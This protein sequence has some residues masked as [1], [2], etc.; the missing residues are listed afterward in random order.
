VD[1]AGR[2]R[3]ALGILASIVPSAEHDGLLV[4]E[5]KRTTLATIQNG[6]GLRPGGLSAPVI[7]ALGATLLLGG[8]TVASSPLQSKPISSEHASSQSTIVADFP[9]PPP[10]Q[11]PRWS[12]LTPGSPFTTLFGGPGAPGITATVPYGD[13]FVAVGLDSRLDGP[14]NGAIWSSPDG[15]TWTRVGVA[16]ADLANVKLDMVATDGRRLIALGR[17]SASD[18]AHEGLDLI[19]WLSD[20]GTD[21]RR[22]ADPQ[23]PF[24]SAAIRGIVGGPSGFVA[25][26][27]DGG[28]AALFHSA[29][30][31]SWERL[32][33]GTLFHGAGIGSVKPYRGGFVAVGGR[34]APGTDPNV[35]TI[36]GP[37]LST[38][39][40][41]WSPDGRTWYAAETETG[42]GLGSV[43]VGADGLLS[44]GSSGH[45]GI[46]RGSFGTLAMDARGSKSG[47][48][49][50]GIPPT[51]PTVPGS[52]ASTGRGRVTFQRPPMA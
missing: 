45:G 9:A 49:C 19:L 31:E 26:G 8:C 28:K 47:A 35:L 43:E 7:A 22:P 4:F 38:A 50:T 27:E 15:T 33:T 12:A 44:V 10:S 29:D 17:P 14:V 41:W 23:S 30:G 34:S 36:G 5:S 3:H 21:W 18:N 46:A 20:D 48:I 11:P 6:Q 37:D 25:W 40:A 39:A 51:R 2:E 42:H 24:G 52:F 13:G 32:L 1:A 16:E